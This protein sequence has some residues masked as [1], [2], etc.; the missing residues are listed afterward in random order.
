MRL[1]SLIFCTAALLSCFSLSPVQADNLVVTAP[2]KR[3]QSSWLE[4]TTKHFVIV[5]D[6]PE[7]QLRRRA[8]RLEQ[9]HAL[10]AKAAPERNDNRLLIYLTDGIGTIQSMAHENSIAGYY[11]PTAMG[12]FAVSPETFQ[13]KEQ[14]WT[15]EVILY[16]EY[17]HHMLLQSNDSYFPG[18]VSEGLAELFA[19]AEIKANGD[20][21]VGA[22]NQSRAIEMFSMNRW[23]AE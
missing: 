21:L 15:P 1:R 17:T 16:H 12:A 18:W 8:M 14:G 4:A 19:T 22:A 10:L 23:S 3:S 20:I 2:D 9:F 6:M 7:S 13:N 5:G 11:I